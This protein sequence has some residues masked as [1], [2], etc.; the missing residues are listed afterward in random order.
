MSTAT[1]MKIC[2]QS[3]TLIFLVVVVLLL[4]LQLKMLVVLCVFFTSACVCVCV[5]QTVMLKSVIQS[6]SSKEP[7]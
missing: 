4:L 2:V 7:A 1:Y 6:D 5:C 3:S